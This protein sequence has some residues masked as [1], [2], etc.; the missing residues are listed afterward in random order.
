M[1]YMMT[2][3]GVLLESPYQVTADHFDL[4]FIAQGL[5]RLGRFVGR[6]SRFLS[7]AEHSV[8]VSRLVPEEHAITGLLHDA[9]EAFVGDL[10]NNIKV[11]LVANG[12]ETYKYLEQFFWELIATKY[13]LPLD[14][15]A[16]VHA[17]D[18]A[19]RNLEMGELFYGNRTPTR[20]N[21]ADA[22]R[23]FL[24]RASDLGLL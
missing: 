2:Q 11:L 7:V 4:H 8:T 19:A 24:G 3:D 5:S 12:E 13:G 15:P 23:L 22:E 14:M 10:H 1:A 21:P 9:T 16:A 18:I 20:C 17:A 6:G